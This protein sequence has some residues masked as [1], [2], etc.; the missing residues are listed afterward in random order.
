[1]ATVLAL[2]T[3]HGLAAHAAD[4]QMEM[5]ANAAANCQGALPAFET[6][7]RKRPLAVQNEGSS[8]AFVTCSFVNEYD[9]AD[10]RQISYFG[11]YFTNTGNAATNVTCTGTAGYQTMSGVTYISKSVQVPANASSQAPMFFMPAD[12]GGNGYYPLVSISCNIPPGVG[13]NDT[14]VS[15]AVGG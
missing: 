3:S 12:N 13:I 11:A 10:Q 1:M 14:Y 15:Y 8:P 9:T 7:I 5:A 4:K 6:A 2:F